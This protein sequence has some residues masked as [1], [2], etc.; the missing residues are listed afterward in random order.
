MDLSPALTHFVAPP[1]HKAQRR[2]GLVVAQDAQLIGEEKWLV[3]EIAAP[4]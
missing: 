3:G 2:R 4:L 1:P